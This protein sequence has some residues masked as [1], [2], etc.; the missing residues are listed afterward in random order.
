MLGEL[1]PGGVP[2]A[3]TTAR[4]ARVLKALRPDGAVETARWE[5]AAQL[6]G[7]LRRIDARIREARKKLAAAVAAAG[8]SLTGLFGVGPVNAAA[9]IGEVRDVSRLG[10]RDRFAAYN[11]TAP[12]ESSAKR[13]VHRLS[14]RGNRRLNQA[15]HM[16][17]ITQVSHRH[18]EGRAYYDKKLTEGKPPKRPCAR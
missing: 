5:L 16:A 13:K 11:G 6:L 17:A 9:G 12:V 2:K 15:I 1:V 4:A 7:D 10:S 3:I 8:T 14:R 18:S